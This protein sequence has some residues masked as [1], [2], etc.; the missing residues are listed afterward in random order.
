M[1]TIQLAHIS[2]MSKK[3]HPIDTGNA[4]T[5]QVQVMSI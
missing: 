2:S 1:Y 5:A 3:L 4:L